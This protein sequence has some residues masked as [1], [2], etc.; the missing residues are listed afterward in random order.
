M[1]TKNVV[2]NKLFKAK[3]ELSKKVDLSLIGDIDDAIQEAES[4]RINWDNTLTD[5]Y[6]E[7]FDVVDRFKN[8]ENLYNEFDLQVEN[9]KTLFSNLKDN[10]IDVGVDVNN[11]PL[12]T[13]IQSFLNR[14][15]DVYAE[16][17]EA[18][19]IFNKIRQN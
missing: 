12:T 11:I 2:F 15:N 10:L 5:L 16:Q 19:G 3:T 6:A 17:V 14:S 1:S 4:T 9:V 13:D 7:L 8:S 18:S